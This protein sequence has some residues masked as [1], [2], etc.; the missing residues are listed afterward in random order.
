M[1]ASRLS[2]WQVGWLWVA[3]CMAALLFSC[4]S[5]SSGDE[6]SFE[7]SIQ[8]AVIEK[9]CLT[10]TV[11]S[12][13]CYLLIWRQPLETSNL[14]RYHIWLDTNV[15][16]EDDVTPPSGATS[17]S[18]IQVDFV[19]RDGIYY[20]TLD[21]TSYMETYVGKQDSVQ[22][23]LWGEYD[24]DGILGRIVRTFVVLG[25]NIDPARV[26]YSDSATHNSLA[27]S[28]T[29]PIDQVDYYHADSLDGPIV[30]YN[31]YF[32]GDD[33]Q[34]MSNVSLSLTLGGVD[35]QERLVLDS[36]WRDSAG[37]L[38]IV[39]VSSDYSELHC[40]II[41]GNGFRGD[42]LDDFVLTIS[43]LQQESAYEL[44]I[45]AYDSAG[46]TSE[47]ETEVL[48]TTDS[49]PPLAPPA[50]WT[51]ADTNDGLVRLDSNR[52][53][54]YWLRAVDPLQLHSGIYFAAD[55]LFIPS[56]CVEKTC[57]R[58]LESYEVQ[59]WDGEEW[60][61]IVD[62]DDVSKTTNAVDD[63]AR[64]TLSGDSMAVDEEGIYTGDTVRWM[65]PGDTVMLRVRSVDSS[66]A[67][68][69]WFTDT[70]HLS[71]GKLASV[72]CPEGFVP[73]ARRTGAD[74]TYG[75]NFC[76]ERFEHMDTDTS[77]DRN[78]LYVDT[79]S[80]CQAMS[81]DSF[82][83]DL[84]PMDDWYS[85]CLSGGV[86]YG[87]IEESSFNAST[88]IYSTCNQGTGDSS[89]AFSLAS[90]NRNCVST[91]GVR[92]LP[93][94]LQE[95]VWGIDTTM[96]TTID[97]NVTP[98]DTTIDT[99]IDT[100]GFLKGSSYVSF[101]T[102]E[103]SDLAK[104]T[105]KGTPMRYRPTYTMDTVY[106]YIV[107][108]VFDTLLEI[109]TS[110]GDVD[111]LLLPSQFTDHL[112]VYQVRHPNDSSLILGYDSLDLAEYNR[113]GGDVWVNAIANGLDYHLV[114]TV[115]VL[116]LGET[117]ARK[118]TRNFY[119]DPSI[120]FRCCARPK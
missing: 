51:R 90:R 37:T 58:Q 107:S 102:D 38:Q 85:A 115:N 114:D 5:D 94:Q 26:Q 117:G 13:E 63:D 29:R 47:S 77:F 118:S 87:V 80:S 99:T 112:L 23:A 33:G 21:L 76:I 62:A 28:W 72:S 56:D 79:R 24:D 45:V 19:D 75:R 15:V 61:A 40:A 6:Y 65:V 9:T 116:L 4:S 83:V 103:L 32:W 74:T 3:V 55:S 14:V 109:D 66:G 49:I 41:D 113:R 81:D 89:S 100:T 111:S 73:V 68:S 96:D 120:G 27:I 70:L 34:D 54:L 88:F 16:S 97:K 17:S 98:Y 91:D 48:E 108:G 50:F 59:M 46:N 86:S 104:C 60:A 95:W 52:L 53:F 1:I 18:S 110:L 92:D 57:Y 8:D 2:C 11:E 71:W 93:G 44:T 35:A 106:L 105:A 82:D 64:W 43:G 69:D 22:I 12:G 78:E 10:D 39:S 7:R 84:C 42:S 119:K 101:E 20:D 67:V 36:R 30:G 25:D 31:I